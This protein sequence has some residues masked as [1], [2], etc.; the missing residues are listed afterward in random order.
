MVILSGCVLLVL[1]IERC[2][3]DT[4]RMCVAGTAD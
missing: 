4:V 3:G 1:L 2:Y